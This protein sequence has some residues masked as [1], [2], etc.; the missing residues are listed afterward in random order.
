MNS[1]TTALCRLFILY[2]EYNV[3]QR[4]VYIEPTKLC[5]LAAFTK[6]LFTGN[7]IYLSFPSKNNIF[8]FIFMKN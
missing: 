2:A 7:L 4:S 3:K 5:D 1:E 8:L 6:D